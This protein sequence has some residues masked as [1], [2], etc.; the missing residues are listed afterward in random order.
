MKKVLIITYSFPPLNNIAARRFGE[1]A[2]YMRSLGWEPIILTTSSKGS[3]P[4]RISEKFIYR[5]GKHPQLTTKLNNEDKKSL[6]RSLLNLKRVLGFN[7]RTI[8]RTYKNWYRYIKKNDKELLKNKFDV[9]LATFG[10]G[11]SLFLGRYYSKKLSIP[12]IADFRDLGALYQDKYYKQNLLARKLDLIVE[13]RVLSSASAI[14]TIG[15]TFV[16]VLKKN[17]NKPTYM[18]YNGW[19]IEQNY[20]RKLDR[21]KYLYYAGRFYP[22][23]M[24]SV[25]MLINT[26]KKHKNINLVI[27]SLGPEPLN[28]KIEEFTK[29]V[30]IID[31]VRILE[32]LEP[33]DVLLESQRALVNIVFEDLDKTIA[34]KKGVITGKLLGLLPLNPP[35]L[36]IARKDSEI[37]EILRDTNKGKLCSSINEIDNFL[38]SVEQNIDKFIGNKNIILY[39][40]QYQAKKICNVLDSV[41]N[42]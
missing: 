16:N 39:S 19:D 2:P 11:A 13:K 23:Q 32:P 40:K 28:K 15:N 5:Y 34:W 21:K 22:H 10:P 26:L 20:G 36:A 6:I 41:L 3:L 25:Y 30:G 14:T 17:Y 24:K 9:I 31:Q 35:V 38:T 37:G 7:L 4:I 12:W 18:I 42:K 1:L 33:K 29:S 27:R 8:D